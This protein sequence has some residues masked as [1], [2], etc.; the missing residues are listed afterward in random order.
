METEHIIGLVIAGVLMVIFGLPWF[1]SQVVLSGDSALGW[2]CVSRGRTIE[3]YSTE[4]ST[5][6]RCKTPSLPQDEE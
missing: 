4:G 1:V 2:Y 6:A 3:F 5:M